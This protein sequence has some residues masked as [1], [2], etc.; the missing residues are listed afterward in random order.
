MA[1]WSRRVHK[2]ICD[3]SE[4]AYAYDCGGPGE[5]HMVYLEEGWCNQYGDHFVSEFSASETIRELMKVQPCSC[6]ACSDEARVR[7]DMYLEKTQ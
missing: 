5:T 6:E 1:R 2:W 3:H 7:A 4:Q